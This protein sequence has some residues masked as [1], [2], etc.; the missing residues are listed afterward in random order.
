MGFIVNK[1]YE[2]NAFTPDQ[3]ADIAKT[4]NLELFKIK[5]GLPEEYSPGASITRQNFD[6][7]QIMTDD[8]KFLRK[9]D[10]SAAL[11]SGL[12]EYPIDYFTSNAIRHN[13]QRN[14][15]GVATTIPRMV[16]ILTEDEASDRLGKW[17]KRPTAWDP[18]AVIRAE[19]IQIYP[20]TINEVE[21]AYIRYP[22]SPNF[23]YVLKTGYIE[24]DESNTVEYEW[25]E[26]LHMD[27]VRIML[28]F[29]GINLRDEQLFQYAEAKKTQGV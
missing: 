25:P 7:S 11:T 20:D 13:Y 18:I 21:F 28:S 19:G 23:V 1:D 14:V 9:L 4:A 10:P 15:D 2:G 22:E 16:E 24:E 8:T 6:A 26:H 27:L 3:F 12:L 17:L 5:M 29:I